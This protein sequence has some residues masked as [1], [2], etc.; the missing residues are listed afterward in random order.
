MVRQYV[1]KVL[2]MREMGATSSNASRWVNKQR[3]I[4]LEG[5][6][7]CGIAYRE[8]PVDPVPIHPIIR[9]LLEQV[10]AHFGMSCNTAQLSM[11]FP[12]HHGAQR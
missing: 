1:C 5:E 12:D 6:L 3:G 10:N 2:Y 4:R 9:F 11:M 8:V 7:G